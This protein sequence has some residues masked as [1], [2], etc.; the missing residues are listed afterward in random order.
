M[1][2]L[3]DLADRPEGA[4]IVVSAPGQA[5]DE[6]PVRWTAGRRLLV[7][8]DERIDDAEARALADSVD[9]GGD[10]VARGGAGAAEV[11]RYGSLLFEAAFGLDTWR[12]IVAA[13][14][15]QPCL[16]LAIRGGADLEPAAGSALQALRWE[17]L[18]DGAAHVAAKGATAST[19]RPLP[20]GIVR[21]VP[22]AAESAV[23]SA[24]RDAG[25]GLPRISHIPR[26]LFA[27]GSRL[28]DPRVRP[29]AEF[30]GILR[31]L[32]RNGGSIQPRLAESA[33]VQSLTTELGRFQPDILHI[34]G[35]G[36]WF[37]VG[38]CVKL[39]LRAESGTGDD[40]VTAGGLL[41]V[42]ADA[43]HVPRVVV[44]S[45]CQT[46]SAGQAAD[47]LNAL[48]FAAR[49]VAGGVPVVVAMAG[50]ISDTA[51]RVFTRALTQAIGDGVPLADA[52]IR[53]RRAAFH[54]RPD[55][56]STDW[57][58][59]AIFLAEHLSGGTS[60]VDTAAIHA[61]RDRIQDLDLAWEPVFCGRADFIAA[62][63]RLL[64]RA[65]PLKVLVACTPDGRKSYGGMRLLRELAA[66]A[67]RAGRLPVL[68]GPYDKD[69]PASRADFAE[70][71]SDKLDEIRRNLALGLRPNGIAAAVAG[72]KTAPLANAILD[73][74]DDLVKD[75][76]ET[77]PVRASPLPQTVL[78]CH[79]VDQWGEDALADLLA[80]LGPRGL[81]S[82]G[83]RRVP[84]VLTGAD[85]GLLAEARL[86]R[87][88]GAAWARFAPL[89]RFRS[90]DEDPED[91][92]AYQ[93][94]LLNPPERTPVYAPRRGADESWQGQLRWVM[95]NTLYDEHELFGFV[96]V[97]SFFFTSD[98]DGDMLDSY[99]RAAP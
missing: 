11:E 99:S 4:F 28:T 38:A 94:W 80:M 91:I 65:D 59:P 24:G 42:F 41:D 25:G 46:A 47:P 75:L 37:P 88:N 30:M 87:F 45:A 61:A 29:G 69:Q 17:A 84:V 95:R 6:R 79:R 27:I 1:R 39:Q 66:R 93:W 26:V 92:L 32:E 51:C 54:A 85:A 97:S 35:H 67:V 44:L 5:S 81:G 10:S 96:K 74:L 63:D 56:D 20:V 55:L 53:G 82:S 68:L 21:L 8:R 14:A 89:G 36:R 58:L 86:V 16:E 15:G 73:A 48:P 23:Q 12:R 64:D 40:W 90:D 18:Y 33:T 3:V 19:G 31:H 2:V 13:A 70:D 98:M 22:A 57:M 76:P 78:L 49:L 77:D 60:M 83:A 50:D 71:L 62:M 43:A 72:T 34:I 52:V 7:A 9:R